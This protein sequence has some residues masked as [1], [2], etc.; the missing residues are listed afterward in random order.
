MIVPFIASTKLTT[1]IW[2]I[3]CTI[4]VGLIIG[5]AL[6]FDLFIKCQNCSN[7]GS[8]LFKS[9]KR[10]TQCRTYRQHNWTSEGWRS[11]RERVDTT[12]RHFDREGRL[13]GHSTSES[14]INRTVPTVTEN[15]TDYF[16]CPDCK[17]NWTKDINQTFDL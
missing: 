9:Y 16:T 15:Y 2:I 7:T 10:A 6:F 5:G 13:S 1:M 8:S 17:Y 12:N 14:W 3:L 11:V 4:L